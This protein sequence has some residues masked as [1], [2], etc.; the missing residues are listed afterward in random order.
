MSLGKA[1]HNV[2]VI[3]KQ[4]RLRSE[5]QMRQGRMAA[6]QALEDGKS[7]REA[8]QACIKAMYDGRWPLFDGFVIMIDGQGFE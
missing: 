6:L 2:E 4:R 1:P 7:P 3:W 5:T 8:A